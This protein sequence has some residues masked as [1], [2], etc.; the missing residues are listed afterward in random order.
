LRLSTPSFADI[1]GGGRFSLTRFPHLISARQNA[2][3]GADD[4]DDDA[5]ERSLRLTAH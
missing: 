3:I 5:V 1:A 2:R 4:D